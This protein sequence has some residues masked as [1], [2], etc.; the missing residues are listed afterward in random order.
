MIIY[1]LR[2]KHQVTSIS[3]TTLKAIQYTAR[4]AMHLSCNF[5]LHKI[6][7]TRPTVEIT[8]EGEVS[9]IVQMYKCQEV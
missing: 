4:E 2:C 6:H 9:S 8:Q 5:I 3:K 1:R 7:G